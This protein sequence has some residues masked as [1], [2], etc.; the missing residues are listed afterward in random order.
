MGDGRIIVE[1]CGLMGIHRKQGGPPKPFPRFTVHHA[2]PARVSL[3]PAELPPS[4]FHASQSNH[5]RPALPSRSL[6]RRSPQA[7]STLHSPTT[8]V[9]RF[10]LAPSGGDPPKLFPRFTVQPRS[11]GASVSLPPAEIPQSYFQAIPTLSTPSALMPSFLP[12]FLPS[13][14]PSFLPPFLPAFLPSL[15][16][17]LFCLAP[18][19]AKEA[20]REPKH[21]RCFWEKTS[22]NPN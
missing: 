16:V 11:S 1:K 6:R 4:Y 3:P 21:R 5:A 14:L 15:L 17:R 7:I 22:R 13:C 18:L 20:K 8:L 9:R 12:F 10:R 2:R 19:A